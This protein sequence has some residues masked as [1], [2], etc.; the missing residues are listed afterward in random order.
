MILIFSSVFYALYLYDISA[1]LGLSMSIPIC[2]TIVVIIGIV[3]K[4]VLLEAKRLSKRTGSVEIGNPIFK[5]IAFP[6][7]NKTAINSM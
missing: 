6:K 2:T 3:L 4:P 7:G 5:A 1:S